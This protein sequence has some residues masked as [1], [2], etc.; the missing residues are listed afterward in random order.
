MKTLRFCIALF[1]IALIAACSEQH[2]ETTVT[3]PDG[4]NTITF[5]LSDNG[6]PTYVVQHKNKMV[7]DT[8]SMGFDFKEGEA[9]ESGFKILKTTTESFDETWEMPWGE[10]RTVRN[11]FNGLLVE[12]QE[13]GDSNRKLNIHF[14]AY[15]DGIAFRYELP[16]Q[17][18]IDEVVIMDENTEFQLT[19]DHTAWWIPG[20]WDIYEHLYNTS[21]VS[22]IDA[23]SKQ[24]WPPLS[25]LKTP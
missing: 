21:K 15:D 9:M 17:E 22:E 1:C 16:K 2:W 20:D 11:H 14:K 24:M 7:I 23:L 19:E 10:Q 12:L 3:S 25:F 18:E 8:S 6:T 13:M 5:H 4:K